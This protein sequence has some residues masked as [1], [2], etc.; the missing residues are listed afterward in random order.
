MTKA[1]KILEDFLYGYKEDYIAI[2]LPEELRDI[3]DIKDALRTLKDI[4]VMK[5][6]EIIKLL[7][8]KQGE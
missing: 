5:A 8:T 2:A 6:Q 4:Q 7:A 3:A 1:I